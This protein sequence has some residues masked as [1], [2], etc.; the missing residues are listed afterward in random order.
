MHAIEGN[1]FILGRPE[2]V[3]EVSVELRR[4]KGDVDRLDTRFHRIMGKNLGYPPEDIEAFIRDP[5]ATGK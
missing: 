4:V 2:N 1:M 5:Q 3:K